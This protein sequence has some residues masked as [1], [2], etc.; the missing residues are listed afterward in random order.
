[1]NYRTREE[2]FNKIMSYVR[3][4][5]YIVLKLDIH[6]RLRP[7]TNNN[8]FVTLLSYHL[9]TKKYRFHCYCVDC[10]NNANGICSTRFTWLPLREMHE[11]DGDN[12][13]KNYCG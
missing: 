2:I 7:W 5:L 13:I 6:R 3:R 4:F 9:S 11:F 12:V 1:M 8:G 10:P